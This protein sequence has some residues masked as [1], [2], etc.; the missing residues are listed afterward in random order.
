MPALESRLLN[1]Q[2][3][4]ELIDVDLI[5]KISHGQYIYVTEI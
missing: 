2:L 3:F 5:V 1:F 4:C